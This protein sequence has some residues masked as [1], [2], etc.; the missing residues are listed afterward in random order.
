MRN[1]VGWGVL[2]LFALVEVLFAGRYLTLDPALFFS[3]QRAIYSAHLTILMMH[4]VGSMVA[5]GLGPFLFLPGWRSKRPALH[6]WLGR[7]YLLG[8]L[9]GGV[10]GLLLSSYAYS[11]ALARNGFATLALLWLATGLMAFLRIRAGNVNDHRRW[12]MRNFALTLAG[13]MLRLQVPLL[14]TVMDF[15]IA[16]PLIAW[17]CWVPNLLIAEWLLRPHRSVGSRPVTKGMLYTAVK[18]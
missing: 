8:N 10:G 1:K 14:T 4:I 9:A 5:L 3:E 16:Y 18:G 12:M 17:L 15:A 6:R 7:V 11:G 2:T 13:V